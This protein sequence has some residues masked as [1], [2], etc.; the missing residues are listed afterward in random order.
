[1]L[2]H[3]NSDKKEAKQSSTTATA[4]RRRPR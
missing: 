2:D 3:C 1:E 4:T